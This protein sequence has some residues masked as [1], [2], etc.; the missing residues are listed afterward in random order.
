M[1]AQHPCFCA[2]NFSAVFQHQ[3]HKS[4][5]YAVSSPARRNADLVDPKFSRLIGKKIIDGR[6]EADNHVVIGRNHN[7]M[8][9][10]PQKRHNR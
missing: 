3:G 10:I 9:L 5:C 7:V 8:P 6:N 4:L 2:T 1:L